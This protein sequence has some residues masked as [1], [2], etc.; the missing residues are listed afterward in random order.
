MHENTSLQVSYKQIH[1]KPT[2]ASVIK[3][4]N[5][6]QMLQINYTDK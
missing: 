3:S 1:W 2:M 4:M 5:G 6:L